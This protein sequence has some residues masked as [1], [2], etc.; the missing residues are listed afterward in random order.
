MQTFTSD[1]MKTPITVS[2]RCPTYGIRNRLGGIHVGTSDAKVEAMIRESVEK[3]RAA[4]VSEWTAEMETE[5]IAFALW[6]HHS[7]RNMYRYVMG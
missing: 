4:G 5:A 1:Y 2:D 6:E 3:Q 7:N